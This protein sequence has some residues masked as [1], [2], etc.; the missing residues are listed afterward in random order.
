MT[1]PTPTDRDLLLCQ[2]V[3]RAIAAHDNRP[4]TPADVRMAAKLLT[5]PF[6][7]LARY[8]WQQFV[9]NSNGGHVDVDVTTMLP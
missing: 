6:C 4:I 5:M 3:A 7:P 8:R 2:V 9:P 1:H